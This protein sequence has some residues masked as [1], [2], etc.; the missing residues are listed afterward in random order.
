MK[1]IL[2]EKKLKNG[3]KSLYLEYYNSGKREFEFLKLYISG[4][5]KPNKQDKTVLELAEKIRTQRENDINHNDFGFL[6]V[7]KQDKKFFDYFE[8][9]KS[10]K[11]SN[12]SVWRQALNHL[13]SYANN[14][15]LKFSDINTTFL[16]YFKGY[17]LV[18]V[19]PGTARG[20]YACLNQVLR[21]AVKDEIIPSNPCEKVSGIK[22]HNSKRA[23][24]TF[25][26]MQKLN[27]TYCTYPEIKRAFLFACYTGLRKSD[28]KS[29]LWKNI[30]N[31]QIELIQG[32]TKEPLYI[33][34]NNDATKLLGEPQ[35][36]EK[37][38]FQIPS[39]TLLG[40]IIK[41]WIHSSGI[42]KPITFH[43]ARHT[44]A[45]LALTY[46]VDVYTVSKLLGHSRVETTQIY[47]KIID[48]KKKQAIQML[49][50]LKVSL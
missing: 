7:N 28:I 38:I 3:N 34:L 19:Q 11:V 5:G 21:Q 1:V 37:H 48:E 14:D 36:P 33:P 17:L 35:E 47:A 40:S 6:K 46:G 42:T 8:K 2:R 31:N 10:L 13:K 45:T 4:N 15:N 41:F 49:P 50:N 9:I 44:F 20:L 25:D 29:L 39:N 12:F 16:E 24:L 43:S 26:E 27:N 22:G 23:Y 18:Q 30:Q 32:K